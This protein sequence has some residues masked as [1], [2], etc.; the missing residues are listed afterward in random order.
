MARGSAAVQRR[1][2]DGGGW[3]EP[4]A[5]GPLHPALALLTRATVD[6]D[7]ADHADDVR[8]ALPLVAHQRDDG[9][10][11]ADETAPASSTLTRVC[12]AALEAVAP[13]AEAPGDADALRDAIGRARQAL[14]RPAPEASLLYR[15]VVAAALEGAGVRPSL[16]PVPFTCLLARLFLHLTWLSR[17]APASVRGLLP[18]VALLTER[19]TRR[20]RVFD[21]LH[22]LADL[23]TLRLLRRSR[24]AMIARLERA[25]GENGLWGWTVVETAVN[26]LALADEETTD[27]SVVRRAAAA[28]AALRQDTPDGRVQSWAGS[29][30]WDTAL[31]LRHLAHAADG[32]EEATA[33]VAGAT[34]LFSSQLDS[35]LFPFDAGGAEGDHDATATAVTGLLAARRHL[36]AAGEPFLARVPLSKG[37]EA[38]LAGQL[39]DGGWGF[40]PSRPDWRF[41]RA[42]PGR[43]RAQLADAGSADLTARVLLALMS[44]RESGS[45][46]VH[47]VDRLDR[48]VDRALRCLRRLQIEDGGFWGRWSGDTIPA[49][50][51]VLLAV[52]AAGI[53]PDEPWVARARQHL[54]GLQ[55]PDG[56]WSERLPGAAGDDVGPSSAEET[57]YAVLGLLAGHDGETP[58]DPPLVRGASWLLDAER[59]G[60]WPSGRLHAFAYA[61]EYFRAPFHTGLVVLDALTTLRDAVRRGVTRALRR[62]R[63]TP[64]PRARRT[65]DRTRGELRAAYEEIRAHAVR[66]A[67]SPRDI[68]QRVQAHYSI[69]LDAR[70]EFTFPL[71]ALHGAAWAAGFFRI[72]EWLSPYYVIVRR[73]FSYQRRR[74]LLESLQRAMTG[75]KQANRLVLIDTYTNYHFSK[76]YGHQ[77]R[78]NLILDVPVLRALNQVHDAAAGG[79]TLTNA[80]KAATY[81]ETFQWEQ[82][83]SVWP[84]VE[85]TIR[86]I[87]DP[88]ARFVGFRPIVRFKYFPWYRVLFF[89][90][91]SKTEERIEEGW[92]AYRIA[93]Q[94]GWFATERAIARYRILPRDVL[95]DRDTHLARYERPGSAE[96]SPTLSKSDPGGA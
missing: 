82:A 74:Q 64:E 19:R 41:G 11:G 96:D 21:L 36:E 78:A 76:R 51:Q 86:D 18:A 48:G 39:A 4:M 70:R 42:R 55:R 83:K 47:Q 71:L 50:A 53:G 72:L 16:P 75:F 9:G 59:D 69:V 35:G 77:A 25:Q 85:R 29:E 67:G 32:A 12:R 81:S 93:E 61:E 43:L 31:A 49:T 92:R 46:S 68:A 65:S 62:R 40:A 63:G 1:Q 52:R 10:F 13:F 73:P 37:V 33:M 45:L 38:L 88:I 30:V 23:A 14:S 7:L 17:R 3:R 44:A 80:M 28:L 57:A 58:A 79:A 34:L 87:D 24:Q 66:L 6:D 90:D 54:A 15:T 56:G 5:A 2:R 89:S 94:V 8:L 95:L 20:L 84:M 22:R 60:W 91:F 26:T 27:Q